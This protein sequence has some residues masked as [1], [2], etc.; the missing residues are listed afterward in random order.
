M[1]SANTVINTGVFDNTEVLW[2]G[3]PP[4]GRTGGLWDDRV[5]DSISALRTETLQKLGGMTAQLKT[6][7]DEAAAC[8]LGLGKDCNYILCYLSF[9]GGLPSSAPLPGGPGPR[10]EAPQ[11]PHYVRGYRVDGPVRRVE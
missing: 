3:R 8:N 6:A 2:L 9:A 1:I 7:L 4:L 10:Q 5:A 11:A